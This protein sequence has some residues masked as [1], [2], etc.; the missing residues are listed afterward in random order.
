[1]LTSQGCQLKVFNCAKL[2]S[3]PT[4][5]VSACKSISGYLLSNIAISGFVLD[6]NK[7]INEQSHTGGKIIIGN[8]VWI[9]A[10]CVILKNVK[11]EDNS[12]IGAGTVVNKDVKKNEVVVGNQQRVLEKKV[13]SD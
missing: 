2:V 9:G 12:V 13:T 1:M 8:N 6:P 7:K 5:C 3:D 11:I 10:N 4:I